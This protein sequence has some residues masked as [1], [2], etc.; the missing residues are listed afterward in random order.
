MCLKLKL[1]SMSPQDYCNR[2][3]RLMSNLFGSLLVLFR[4]SGSPTA[5][6]FTHSSILLFGIL[7]NRGHA[8]D[9]MLASL[10]VGGKGIT[11]DFS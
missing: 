7:G 4:S 1:S 2:G 9:E 11:G 5:L 3:L 6:S 8:E 10:S